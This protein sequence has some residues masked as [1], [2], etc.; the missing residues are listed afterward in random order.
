MS[1]RLWHAESFCMRPLERLQPELGGPAMFRTPPG[2]RAT[3]RPRLAR[4]LAEVPGAPLSAARSRPSRIV[5]I[6]AVQSRTRFCLEQTKD[7]ILS[8]GR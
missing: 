8:Q 4:S 5:T 7:L 1:G 2:C 3:I 6:R